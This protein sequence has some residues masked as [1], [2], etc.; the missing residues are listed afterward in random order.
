MNKAEKCINRR[1]GNVYKTKYDITVYVKRIKKR[2]RE[3]KK[4][5]KDYVM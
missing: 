2:V 4:T 5:N 1:S 3:K